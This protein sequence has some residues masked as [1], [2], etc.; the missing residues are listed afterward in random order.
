MLVQ[1]VEQG[2]SNMLVQ[3]VEQG[4]LNMLVQ[5]MEQGLL[6]MLVQS[7]E[8]VLLN[9]VVVCGAGVIVQYSMCGR[10]HDPMCPCCIT[11]SMT[12]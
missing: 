7:M 12:E 10:G 2:L 3:S 5:Y 1:S 4:L 6:H 9:M 11:S 8:Q